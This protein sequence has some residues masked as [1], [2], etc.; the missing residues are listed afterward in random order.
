MTIT[1]NQ[2]YVQPSAYVPPQQIAQIGI[3]ANTAGTN[4]STNNTYIYFDC[5]VGSQFSVTLGATNTGATVEAINPQP[6]QQIALFL[7]QDST[8]SRTVAWDSW[9]W[10]SGTAPTL[11]TTGSGTDVIRGMWNDTLAKWV[12]TSNTLYIS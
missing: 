3:G 11:T 10:A 1:T 4:A 9:L 2:T 8:G 6:G 5:S 7:K 12:N